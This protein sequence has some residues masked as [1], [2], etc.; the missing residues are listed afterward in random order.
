MAGRSSPRSSSSSAWPSSAWSWWSSLVPSTY[1]VTE[2]GHAEYGGGPAGHDH[3]GG[4]PV[5]ELTGP[6][7]ASPDVAVELAAPGARSGWPPARRYPGYT[8]NGTSPGPALEVHQ[9][10]LV[11][12]TLTN[13]DVA[14]GGDPALARGGRAQRRGRRGR[15]HPGRR[16]APAAGTS[17][18]SSP[19][20]PARTGTT[21]TR[22]PTS[23]CAAACS[24]PWSCCPT[25]RGG[26]R[27]TSSRRC[28]PTPAGAPS[29]AAPASRRSK[30]RPG[31]R[32]RVRLVNTDNGPLR[33]WVSGVAVPGGRRRRHAT[34]TS[35]RRCA[36][37]GVV[38][39]AGG[40]VDVLVTAPARRRRRRRDGAGRRAA[41]HRRRAAA[42]ARPAGRPAG[43]RQPRGRCRSTR[44]RPD[45][46]FDFD[47]G[48]RIGFVDGRPGFWWTINGHAVPRRADVPRQEGD[49]VRMTI[50]NDSGDVHPMHLHGHHADRAVPQRRRRRPAARGWSTR[51]TCRRRDATRSP[52]SPT[53]RASGWTTATTSTT[54]PTGLIA[55]LAYAGVTE[56][57]RVGGSAA[58][59]PE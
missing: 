3:A 8:L 47:I 22:S 38:V 23:R 15:R 34:S 17:T 6:T 54:P 49:V 37:E 56:P 31:E 55:H 57:Y 50:S 53:T 21:P 58:N 2:M 1:S 35:R 44:S 12:V 7:T 42:R 30:R 13:V 5:A 36:A 40:R 14:R 46:R 16:A 43:L 19:R 29:W 32:V 9:G 27:R 59:E 28:T 48:R 51:S 25:D 33:A 11:Q 41:R 4:R 52:S 45:R 18:G 10:D 39:T 24:A 20:T 26:T